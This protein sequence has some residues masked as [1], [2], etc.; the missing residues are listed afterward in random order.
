MGQNFCSNLRAHFKKRVTRATS[1]STIE[2]LKVDP[3][4]FKGSPEKMTAMKLSRS[5]LGGQTGL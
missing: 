3:E 5:C 2:L 4:S 1:R